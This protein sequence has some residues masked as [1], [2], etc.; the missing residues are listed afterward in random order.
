MAERHEYD[1]RWLNQDV[2]RVDSA[3]RA[4]IVCA[5]PEPSTFFGALCDITQEALEHAGWQTT[6]T[7]LQAADFSAKSGASDAGAGAFSDG[8]V[9]G[10][11]RKN[12]FQADGVT[13]ENAYEVAMVLRS[14]LL[15]L[16]FPLLGGAVPAEITAWTN[17]VLLSGVLGG[18]GQ[19]SGRGEVRAKHAV[20]V[21]SVGEREHASSPDAKYVDIRRMLSQQ[22]EGVLGQMGF[23]LYAPFVA[24]HGPRADE[25]ARARMLMQL[26]HDLQN[27]RCRSVLAMPPFEDPNGGLRAESCQPLAP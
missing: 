19:A 13:T 24:C 2:G 8:I 11:A 9:P 6:M 4:H 17:R 1:Q 12:G 7:Y 5:H 22:L 23:S 26:F 18:D 15:V 21:T 16:V 10:L 14:D 25:G 20:V 27:V 3:K